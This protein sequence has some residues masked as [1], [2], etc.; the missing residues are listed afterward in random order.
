MNTPCGGELLSASHPTRK[1][2]SPRWTI[3]VNGTNVCQS[4]QSASAPLLH[5]SAEFQCRIP[6]PNSSAGLVQTACGEWPPPQR[7]AKLTP[8]LHGATCWENCGPIARLAVATPDDFVPVYDEPHS[9]DSASRNSSRTYVTGR[10]RKW[11][12][13]NAATHTRNDSR[14]WYPYGLP[15]RL[16]TNSASGQG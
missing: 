13:R 15:I 16:G 3:R 10:T 5:R 11:S 4:Q 8:V 9:L 1:S 2:S 14:C 7:F 12:N 6:A